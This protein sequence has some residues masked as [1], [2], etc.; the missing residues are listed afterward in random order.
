MLK[1]RTITLQPDEV[2]S[3]KA[4]H[5]PED[6]VEVRL[7]TDDMER[8]HIFVTERPFAFLHINQN[9][10]QIRNILATADRDD[11]SELTFH[12]GVIS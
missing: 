4:P 6:R 9:S 11:P 3:I 10:D 8:F 7:L 5:N 2:L 1:Q 12:N